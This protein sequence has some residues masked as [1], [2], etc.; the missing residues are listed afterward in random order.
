M[1]GD[2]I[3]LNVSY[4]LLY[5]DDIKD[6]AEPAVSSKIY[7]HTDRDVIYAGQ[8]IKLF[9]YYP[10]GNMVALRYK[11]NTN[12][13]YNSNHNGDLPS[14]EGIE[15][16]KAA[17]QQPGKYHHQLP[18]LLSHTSRSTGDTSSI[19]LRVEID[20]SDGSTASD[21]VYILVICMYMK[22]NLRQSKV[23]IVYI[24]S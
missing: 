11:A 21:D 3:K 14:Y 19:Q 5:L 12:V 1:A 9:N 18:V 16:D 22:N 8:K 13:I 24:S 6:V 10:K 20:Y 4:I 2:W 7:L 15:V 17:C 23:S